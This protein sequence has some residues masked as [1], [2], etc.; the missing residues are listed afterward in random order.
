[1]APATDEQFLAELE[2]LGEEAVRQRVAAGRYSRF[3]R[4]AAEEWL[5]SRVRERDDAARSAELELARRS[6]D[7]S[8]LAAEAAE[9]SAVAAERSALA[10]ESQAASALVQA[11]AARAAAAEAVRNSQIAQAANTRATIAI[12][13]G[14]IGTISSIVMSILLGR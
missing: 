13:V 5:R 3:R 10:A 7:A 14:I 1:M 2:I 6:G 9:R 4:Q 8:R 12:A 11:D